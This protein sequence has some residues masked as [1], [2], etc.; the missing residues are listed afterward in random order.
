MS[1]EGCLEHI[2]EVDTPASHQFLIE[3]SD[4]APAEVGMFARS[5]FKVADGRRGQVVE[6]L[7]EMAE[8]N[9]ELDFSAAFKVCLKDPDSSV[10]RMAISG[11]WEFED[12]SLIVQLVELLESDQSGEVRAEAAVALGKFAALAQDGKILVKD[13]E[14]VK[15]SLM[16]ALLNDGEWV[17]V[18]RRALE[19]VAPFNTPEIYRFI[20]RAYDSEDVKLKCSSLYAMGK[21][22]EAT[23][24]PLIFRELKNPS[25]PVR[26]EAAHA[27]GQMDDAGATPYLL[28]LLHDDDLQVQLA[29]IDALGEIGDTLAKRALIRC[30]KGG[31]SILEDAARAALENIKGMEDPLGFNYE[32]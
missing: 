29:V 21:T 1:L 26:Y 28:P 5:W 18:G 23:W 20:H 9:A 13:G 32:G 27:C 2:A 4:L 15:E 19:S 14:R 30:M 16:T 25:P 17:E 8:D 22:G 6:L 11:L 3:L 12:R 10:R 31:D 7:V 24:L